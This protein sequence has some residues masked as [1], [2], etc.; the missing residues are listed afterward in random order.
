[1]TA[2]PHFLT[3]T[4]KRWHDAP[5]SFVRENFGVEPDGWQDE[6]LHLIAKPETRR[7]ALKAC[8]GPGKTALLAWIIL[9]FLERLLPA[10]A[11]SAPGEMTAWM[12]VHPAGG[13]T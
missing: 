9:W 6:A 7:L 4:V 12:I 3:G 5:W 10:L 11:I 1:M 2:E 13:T 8:K